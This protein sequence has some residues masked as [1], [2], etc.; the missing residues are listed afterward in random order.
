MSRRGEHGH[1][2]GA[3]KVAYADFVTAMMA[4]FIVLWIIGT[5][6]ET[7]AA[8]SSYFRHPSIIKSG[9]TGFLS[10]EGMKEY[11]EAVTKIETEENAES[12]AVIESAVKQIQ[13]Q[14]PITPEELDERGVLSRSARALEDALNTT[15]ELRE[16][17][18][19]VSIEFT[20]QGMR[21]QIEDLESNAL[22]GLGSAE[23]T[24]RAQELLLAVSRILAPLPNA[25]LV[26]GHTDSRP[27]SGHGSYTNWELSGDRANAARRILE[28]GG[29]RPER[30]ARVVGYADRRLLIAG[31]PQ[32]QHNRRISIIVCYQNA[33][34]D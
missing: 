1:H 16:L 28:A 18:A 20:S 8:I 4:L 32:S 15:E 21:I 24:P 25:I 2:G 9:G 31:D 22:F 7:K 30:I 17:K 10:A 27:F 14:G 26:E 34:L 6:Q 23:P 3:W 11:R 29:C 5:K 19:Q 12:L 13:K 33:K